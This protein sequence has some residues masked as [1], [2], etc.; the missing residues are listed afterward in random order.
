MTTKYVVDTHALVWFLKGSPKLGAV[1]RSAL[2][3]PKS[4]L[5]LPAMALAEALWMIEHGRI[6]AISKVQLL[7]T[8]DRDARF[9]I[10][11]LDRDLVA[12]A[13]ELH[14][15][16]E[17]HDRQ[18]ADRKLTQHQARSE[19]VCGPRPQRSLLRRMLK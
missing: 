13:D 9:A 1:A 2:D 7:S 8:V 14:T 16:H 19:G 18:I 10:E 11:P 4:S 15:I 17:M 5:I 12:I 3:D 6:D